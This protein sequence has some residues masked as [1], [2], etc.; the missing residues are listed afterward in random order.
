MLKI[1]VAECKERNLDSNEN[2]A[3]EY[4]TSKN[5]LRKI[6]I[7]NELHAIGKTL[8]NQKI[9]ETTT[10][11]VDEIIGWATINKHHICTA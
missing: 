9:Y 1:K 3:Y 4:V 6:Q 5:G 2:L 11:F 10:E 8:V 7:I